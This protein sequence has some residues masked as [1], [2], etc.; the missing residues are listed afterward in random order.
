MNV[1]IRIPILFIPLKIG[2]K[3]WPFSMDAI[4]ERKAPNQRSSTWMTSIPPIPGLSIATSMAKT[5]NGVI[6]SAGKAKSQFSG[7]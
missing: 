1:S 6:S 7:I 4:G 2:R 3:A 5:A